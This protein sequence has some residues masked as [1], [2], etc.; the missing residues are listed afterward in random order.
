MHYFTPFSPSIC[1][2]FEG[3]DYVLSKLPLSKDTSS[4]LLNE[5]KV[6]LQFKSILST[7]CGEAK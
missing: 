1:S 2:R 4:L 6:T 3:M 5:R 7:G